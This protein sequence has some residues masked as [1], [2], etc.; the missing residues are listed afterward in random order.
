MLLKI[1][2]ID[3]VEGR[4]VD[5]QYSNWRNGHPPQVAIYECV[6][7]DANN[8]WIAWPCYNSE[9]YVCQSQ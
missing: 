9:T 2:N 8:E 4:S 3:I 5:V 1:K 6:M 7:V